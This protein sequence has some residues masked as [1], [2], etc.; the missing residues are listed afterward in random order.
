MNDYSATGAPQI[1]GNETDKWTVHQVHPHP[2]TME[3]GVD[4]QSYEE[5]LHYNAYSFDVA[6]AT[7]AAVVDTANPLEEV[8]V[9]GTKRP[10]EV[11]Q[12]DD[13]MSMK[14]YKTTDEGR[15]T[16]NA[17]TNRQWDAMFERLV[18]FKQ[19]NGVRAAGSQFGGH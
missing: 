10:L 8:A 2:T 17:S 6:H 3:E 18:A 15:R 16:P 4:I 9:A 7:A 5:T 13:P 14:R 19:R 1:D 12:T 11:E